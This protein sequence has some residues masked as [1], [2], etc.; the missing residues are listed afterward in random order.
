MFV[1]PMLLHKSDQAF[2]DDNYITELKLDGFRA[3][4]SKFNDKVKIY[5]RHNNEV[6]S[7]FPELVNLPL[8]NGIVLDGEIIV[9]DNKG[10]PDFEAVMERFMSIKSEHNISYSVFDIIYYNGEKVTNLPLLERKDLVNKVI[11]ED[12]LLINKVQWIE[13]NAKQ[14]FELI[15]QHELEGIVQKKAD[16]KYQI[17]KRSHDWLKVINYQYENVYISGLRK[18]KFGLLLNFDNGKYAGLMEFMP[19]ANRNEFYK[20]YGD[21]IVE[22]N[23]KFIY[24]DSKLKAKVKYRNITKKGLLRIPS[25]VEWAN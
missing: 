6:T 13:G 5:T 25:F 10:R 15:Q 7:K 23:D 14:Y 18:D 22:E 2:D 16:S 17:N 9:T 12:T 1:S 20:L 8:P 11:P 24:L 19:T 3:I 21:F 4:L